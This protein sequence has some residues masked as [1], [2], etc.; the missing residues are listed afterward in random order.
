MKKVIITSGKFI[1]YYNEIVAT[2][3]LGFPAYRN[4]V[5][6]DASALLISFNSRLLQLRSHKR[7][8]NEISNETVTVESHLAYWVVVDSDDDAIAL[9]G[10]KEP[11]EEKGSRGVAGPVGKHV[12]PVPESPPGNIGRMG[13]VGSRGGIGARAEKG[14]K[15]DTSNV[16]Q[17]R[18]VG[19]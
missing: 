2:H 14:D 3:R 6:I 4:K 12:A 9:Q 5:D 18:P 11:A 7:D 1:D 15:G 10:D 19:P 13:P 16:G 8:L 17:Q